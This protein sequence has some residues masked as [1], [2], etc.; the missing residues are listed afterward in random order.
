MPAIRTASQGGNSDSVTDTFVQALSIVHSNKSF[1][2][3]NVDQH[4]AE[5][6]ESFHGHNIYARLANSIG[7]EIFGME[8]V[9]KALL[10]Q[11]VGAPTRVLADGMKIRGDV[12]I[13]L[14]GDPGVAK[15]SM[16][17]PF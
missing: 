1:A 16:S 8:D 7:P 11:M 6:I 12:N 5:V 4:M 10:L 2:A 3:I 13:L 17:S 9:K 15:V 14:M